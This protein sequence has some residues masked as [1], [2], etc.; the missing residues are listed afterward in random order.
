MTCFHSVFA[1]IAGVTIFLAS[2][3]HAVG[4]KFGERCD[5]NDFN[6]C[7]PMS[8]VAC[9]S[10]TCNCIYPWMIFRQEKNK[11]LSTVNQ[12][13][14][15]DMNVKFLECVENAMCVNLPDVNGFPFPQC[16]CK[17]GYQPVMKQNCDDPDPALVSANDQLPSICCPA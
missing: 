12:A 14:D 6:G 5:P 2:R 13:C 7:D 11:C 8:A 3:T 15:L 16:I 17:R 10:L 1:I 9:L 4:G